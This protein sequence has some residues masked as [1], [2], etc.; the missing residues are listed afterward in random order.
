MSTTPAAELARVRV[1]FAAWVIRPAGPGRDRGFIAERHTERGFRSVY[2]PTLAELESAL[3][4]H[5]PRGHGP[6]IPLTG[7]L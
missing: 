6:R 5:G 4:R 1:R 2:A 7:H 3:T